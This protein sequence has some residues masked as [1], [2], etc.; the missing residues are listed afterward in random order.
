MA[1]DRSRQL[2][3]ITLIGI[4]FILIGV[5]GLAAPALA[6]VAI[7]QF[8]AWLLLFAG[9]SGLTFAWHM[10][11]EEGSAAHALVAALTTALAL[12]FLFYPAAGM[13]TLT[14]LLVALF[15][16]EGVASVLFGL[17]LKGRSGGWLWM[18]LSGAT[19]LLVAFVILAGWPA[20]TTWI[21][22]LLVG[23]N[24]LSTGIS[25]VLLSAA[26]RKGGPF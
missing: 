20:T 8:I 1:Y 11:S 17:R 18:I 14:W 10:R 19:A 25:L 6:T 2:R 22:G 21:L 23:V 9:V 15:V 26:M 7:E 16:L 24:F 12:I 4:A 13:A 5:I 3:N